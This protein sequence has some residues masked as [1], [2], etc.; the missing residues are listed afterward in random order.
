MFCYR[1]PTHKFDVFKSSYHGNFYV[2]NVHKICRVHGI[3]LKRVDYNEPQKGKDQCDREAALARNAIRKYVDEG[4]NLISANDIRKALCTSNLIN[5]KVSVVSFN[6][7]LL[8]GT[9]IDKISS[10]HSYEISES[11]S[12]TALRYYNLG[13]GVKTKFDGN[14]DTVE[15]AINVIDPWERCKGQ[16]KCLQKSERKDRMLCELFF[17]Q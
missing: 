15:S 2:E 17:L 13:Q 8:T 16:R 14:S 1:F 6:K 12:I 3:N 11:N 7:G 4:N 5:T 9:K 10:Y